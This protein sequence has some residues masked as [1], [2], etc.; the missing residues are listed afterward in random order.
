MRTAITCLLLLCSA[1]PAT[2][3]AQ[4]VWRCGADGRTFTDAPCP[5]GQALDTALPRPAADLQSAQ[6]QAQRESVWAHQLQRERQQRETQATPGAAGIYGLRP[7]KAVS[8]AGLKPVKQQ[9]PQKQK[10]KPKLQ[11]PH[12]LEAADS[13][14]AIAASTRQKKD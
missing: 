11:T 14:Q 1:A 7:V 10:Q 8:D 4:T 5:Q 9:K 12:R 2:L 13:G 6:H 3:Q